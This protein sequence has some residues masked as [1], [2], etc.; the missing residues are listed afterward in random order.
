MTR[1]RSPDVFIIAVLYLGL[2]LSLSDSSPIS[3]YL[4]FTQLWKPLSDL[5]KS[6]TRRL[7]TDSTDSK[8]NLI[9]PREPYN[10]QNGQTDPAHRCCSSRGRIRNKALP[11]TLH[12]AQHPPVPAPPRFVHP[13]RRINASRPSLGLLRVLLALPHRYRFRSLHHSN[14]PSSAPSRQLGYIFGSLGH[15]LP[16]SRMCLERQYGSRIRPPSGEM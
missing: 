13:L 9:Q 1:A 11:T 12:P 2:A 14:S 3:A 10:S 6:R 15:R 16:R 5:F 8:E 7:K 4:G